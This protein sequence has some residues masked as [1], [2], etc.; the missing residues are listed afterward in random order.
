MTWEHS[1]Y[2]CL[3]LPLENIYAASEITGALTPHTPAHTHNERQ[4]S[5]WGAYSSILLHLY[6]TYNSMG[7]GTWTYIPQQTRPVEV[8]SPYVGPGD[9]TEVWWQIPLPTKQSQQPFRSKFF[10]LKQSWPLQFYQFGISQ[11]WF[12]KIFCFNMT[13]RSP[14]E[15]S[16]QV[17]SP[18]T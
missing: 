4:F 2:P 1:E 17:H 5:L 3:T 14:S 15:K 7:A 10:K 9:Q 18:E 12:D 16:F 8:V 6:H 13:I 11:I